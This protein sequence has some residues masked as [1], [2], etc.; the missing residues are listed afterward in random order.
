MQ[1]SAEGAES[2][3]AFMKKVIE[4]LALAKAESDKY[5]TPL[6]EIRK[7]QLGHTQ[8]PKNNQ[9]NTA[10]ATVAAVNNVAAAG[11]DVD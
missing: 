7:Q 3:Q 2:N 1:R 8:G 10:S 6:V 4:G 5:L 9:S 11:M